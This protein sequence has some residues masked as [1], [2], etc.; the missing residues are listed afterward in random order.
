MYTLKYMLSWDG[1]KMTDYFTQVSGT[2]ISI[3]TLVVTMHAAFGMLTYVL[4]SHSGAN[5][6]FQLENMFKSAAFRL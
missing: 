4:L 2:L 6:H 1:E 3:P 5:T